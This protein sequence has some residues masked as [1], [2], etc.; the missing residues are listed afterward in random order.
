MI[1]RV[2]TGANVQKE[3]PAPT[4]R[5][6]LT[7]RYLGIILPLVAT[8]LFAMLSVFRWDSSAGSLAAVAV[9]GAIWAGCT[10]FLCSRRDWAGAGAISFLYVLMNAWLWLV[11]LGV[12]NVD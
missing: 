6:N 2:E 1:R 10:V 11:V 5:L 3:P 4:R 9:G 7:L 12:L 8:Y